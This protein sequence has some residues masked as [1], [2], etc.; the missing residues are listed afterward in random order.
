[1]R[2]CDNSKI[3]I[4][5]NFI[6]SI[7]LLIM[8]ITLQHLATL[9]HTTPNYTVKLAD[10][11]SFLL[12]AYEVIYIFVF[13]EQCIIIMLTNVRELQQEIYQAARPDIRVWIVSGFVIG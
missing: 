6:L 12:G 5:S 13:K 3:H 8:F 4:S 9:N 2:G 1:M 11:V 10:I 7:C